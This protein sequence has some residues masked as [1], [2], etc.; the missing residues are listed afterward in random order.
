MTLVYGLV[1]W[2]R[3]DYYRT[4]S[5]IYGGKDAKLKK[6]AA[7]IFNPWD[8]TINEDTEAAD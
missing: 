3:V 7:I 8:W 6:F 4:R 5:E 2:I 1:K